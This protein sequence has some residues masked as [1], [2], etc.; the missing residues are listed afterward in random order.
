MSRQPIHHSWSYIPDSHHIRSIHAIFEEEWQSVA[1]GIF[2][3]LIKHDGYD[4]RLRERRSANKMPEEYRQRLP[5]LKTR[6]QG[7]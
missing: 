6:S 3:F 1:A 7:S 4:G 2:S 5:M